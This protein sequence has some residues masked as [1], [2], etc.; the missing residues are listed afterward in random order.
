MCHVHWHPTHTFLLFLSLNHLIRLCPH[1]PSPKAPLQVR[2][3]QLRPFWAQLTVRLTIRRWSLRWV[4]FLLSVHLTNQHSHLRSVRVLLSV[5]LTIQPNHLPT[6][7]QV[8]LL[9][10]PLTVH[11]SPL[12]S[13][14]VQL[15]VL[16][17]VQHYH[18]PTVQHVVLLP[19]LTAQLW[20]QRSHLRR[21]TFELGRKTTVVEKARTMMVLVYSL[22]SL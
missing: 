5:P 17:T 12:R 16:L 13:V 4:W 19:P 15:S 11:P 9:S 8:V 10:V 1:N 18:L 21:S 22:L 20:V 2:R 7:H 3:S 14:W 6:V